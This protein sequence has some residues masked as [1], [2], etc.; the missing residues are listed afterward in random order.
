[1]RIHL[2]SRTASTD[3]CDRPCG[4]INFRLFTGVHG[5]TNRETSPGCA[6]LTESPVR[7]P[8]LG[9]I[10]WSFTARNVS[11]YARGRV[12]RQVGSITVYRVSRGLFVSLGDT[13][14]VA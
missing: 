13:G 2:R 1:M 9:L 12:S 3:N 4:R 5:E 10:L 7:S 14:K 11:G 6:Q 8:L